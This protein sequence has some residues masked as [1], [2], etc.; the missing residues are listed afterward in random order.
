[1]KKIFKEIF[2][3]YMMMA[4]GF[5]SLMCKN[6]MKTYWWKIGQEA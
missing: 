3:A 6:N 2:A 4:K 1:M 5:L